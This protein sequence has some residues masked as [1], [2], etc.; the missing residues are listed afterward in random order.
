MGGVK[1]HPNNKYGNLSHR[2][3]LFRCLGETWEW[4][5]GVRFPSITMYFNTSGNA[6][7]T[8][9]IDVG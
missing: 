7:V 3:E 9:S 2:S 6:G 8:A 4:G 1:G 5:G